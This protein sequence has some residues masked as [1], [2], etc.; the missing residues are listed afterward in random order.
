[1]NTSTR[2][3]AVDEYAAELRRQRGG[4][5]SA[6]DDAARAAAEGREPFDVYHG[7]DVFGRG[8]YG[9]GGFDS[10]GGGGGGRKGDGSPGRAGSRSFLTGGGRSRFILSVSALAFFFS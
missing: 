7:V 1:M 10:S 9:G 2:R 4:A 8:T 6:R 3:W 5:P